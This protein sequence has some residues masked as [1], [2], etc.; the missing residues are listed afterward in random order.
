DDNATECYAV[1]SFDL[2]VNSGLPI[3]DP[4]P[5]ELCDDLGEENDGMTAFDLTQ[6]N[7]EITNG[8]LTQG[9]TYFLTEE[10]AQN[11]E[12]RI[13]PDTAYVNVDPNGNPVN[14]QVLYVRV[15]DGNSA[16]VSFTTLTIRVISNP[17]PVTPD[18]IV[19]CDYNVIVPPGPYDEVELFDLT[20]REAQ[21]R[22]GNNWTLDYYESYGDAVTQTD[23]I[24]AADVTAYQNTGNPQVVYVRATS[25][26]TGCFEIV[27]LELIV[28]PLPD[29]SA[30]V[31]P[32]VYCST[33]GT[34]I[35]VFDLT[36]KI[37]EILGGQ[38]APPMEVSFYLTAIDAEN[39]TNAITNVT[40]HRNM[41][42]GNNPINPQTIFTGITNTETGCYIGGVQSFELIVQPGA[43]AVAPAEPFVICDN[44]MPSDGFAE[45]DLEDMSD[46]Q[47]VDL[48]AGILAGQDPADFGITFHETLEGAEA[49]T[50]AIVFPYVNIINPQRIYVRVTN[51]TNIYEPSCYSVV[52]MIL[53]VEQL[54]DVVLADQYR[55]CVDG[56][57]NPIAAEEGGPSPPVIDTGLDPALFTFQWELDGVIVAGQTGPSIIALVPGTYT[58]TI[59]ELSSGCQ[60]TAT[61]TVIVSSPP[62]TYGAVLVNGAFAEDHTIEVT[63]TG[64]GTYQYQLDD[65]PFQDSN[66]FEDVSPGNHT[67]TIRDANGC[68]SVTFDVGV[69]DYPLYFTPNGDGYHDTWNII[70]IASGDPTAKIYIFD[71]FGKLLKQLSPLGQGWDGTFGGRP[72]PSSD[73]WFRVEYTE[74][75]IPK[76]FK[77][78]FTLKR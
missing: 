49:G 23:A 8:V 31:E 61:T 3:T 72:M 45:F 12:N 46:Q 7:S 54:P 67:I 40:G 13:D 26:T 69:I 15:E 19:L 56:N 10:D 41:D 70:G 63:A 17:N 2:V 65:G 71:R 30:T 47:V 11:N 34:E 68:G 4:T 77:G 35:G 78:H 42:A 75:E 32:Y 59:T 48:R 52:E 38:P 25:P 44:L 20:V 57:G 73:Y 53:K 36:T 28:E 60:S 51:Q 16:C 27:E 1:G 22:N 76:E 5:L 9:V 14:P 33:D 24:P 6:K 39:S 62:E 74:N 18:P 29:D 66:I 58:V 43:V 21:I 37:G 50:G 55:L 64:Q